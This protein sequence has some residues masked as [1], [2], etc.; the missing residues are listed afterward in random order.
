[1]INITRFQYRHLVYS[2]GCNAFKQQ[3]LDRYGII[4]LTVHD[5]YPAGYDINFID[6]KAELMF[7]LKY[8]NEI[9]IRPNRRYQVERP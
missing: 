9:N 5:L 2:I 8:S 1:M 6:D 3:L 7:R 4:S